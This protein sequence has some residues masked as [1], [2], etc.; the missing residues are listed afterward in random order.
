MFNAFYYSR[1]IISNNIIVPRENN[2]ETNYSTLPGVSFDRK[3][4]R[5]SQIKSAE[6]YMHICMGEIRET[7]GRL[8]K[9]GETEAKATYPLCELVTIINSSQSYIIN[10]R[11]NL[12]SDTDR[13]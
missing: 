11:D 5:R 2:F 3:L 6:V 13:V 7:R 9:F 4:E 10:G 12:I 1:I 8:I